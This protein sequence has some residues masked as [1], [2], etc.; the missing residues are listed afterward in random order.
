MQEKIGLGNNKIIK[1]AK[2][3]AEMEIAQKL[4]Y[5]NIPTSIIRFYRS[6]NHN[7]YIRSALKQQDCYLETNE[8]AELVEYFYLQTCKLRK[9]KAV[10][11]KEK[12]AK[13]KTENIKKMNLDFVKLAHKTIE[14]R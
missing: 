4:A 8:D 3:M 1:N 2:K 14:K 11:S 10:E 6:K 9:N 7:E 5:G 12:S 13:Q